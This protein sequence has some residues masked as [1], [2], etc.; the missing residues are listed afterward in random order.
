MKRRQSK[1]R[2]SSNLQTA[3]LGAV[4]SAIVLLSVC[5]VGA[6]AISMEWLPESSAAVFAPLAVGL[7]AFLGPLPLIRRLGRRPLPI[8][9]G[10]MLALLLV[11]VLLRTILW[12]G[13]DFG[14]WIVPACAVVG[15]AGAG[16]AGGH[17]R[18][19]R[20]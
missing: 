5:A 20:R 7:S 8:A 9:Y 4:I 15:A 17:R 10:Q 16:M 6:L 14:G 18:G 19:K 11:L 1:S 2:S 3:A 12:P 13:T